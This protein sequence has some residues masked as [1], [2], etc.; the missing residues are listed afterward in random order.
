MEASKE[1]I[2]VWT[3]VVAAED[4]EIKGS[5]ATLAIMLCCFENECE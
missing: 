2:E 4:S 3:I 1:A 5:V